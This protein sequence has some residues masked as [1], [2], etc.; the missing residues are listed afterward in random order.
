MG[1]KSKINGNKGEDIVKKL[2][3]SKKYWVHVIK[4]DRKG[5]Q[6]CD[7]VAIKG[8]WSGSDCAWLVDAKY[9]DGGDRFDFSD[10]QPN[11]IEAMEYASDYAD[12][13]NI[14][15]AIVFSSDEKVRFL[16]YW[17][18]VR[19]LENGNRSVKAEQLP[20]LERLVMISGK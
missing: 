20:E 6:P 5:A 19:L 10:I 3:V 7:I 14:G 1:I 12:I 4:R 17:S 18:Y 9:V 2:F 11:Q 8:N 16:S 13:R 15:F